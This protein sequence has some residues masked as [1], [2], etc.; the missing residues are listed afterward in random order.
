MNK[1]TIALII[2]SPFIL[3]FKSL[4]YYLKHDWETKL[5]NS[6]ITIMV[7]GFFAIFLSAIANHWL[8]TFFSVLGSIIFVLYYIVVVWA[9]YD[10]YKMYPPKKDD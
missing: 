1:K 10:D 6:I 8:I 3:P 9:T 2:I 5:T 7:I 4:W